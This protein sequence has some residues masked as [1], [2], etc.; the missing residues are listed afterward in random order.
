[1]KSRRLQS[2]PA[3][4]VLFSL[5]P[6]VATYA[7]ITGVTAGTDL[8]GGGTSG[9]VTLNVNT[10]ALNSAYAQLTAANTFTGNQTVNGN[11]SATGVV[12]GGSY[13]I[14]SNLFAF[15][16]Y[17]NANAFL[18]FA[19]NTT[20]TGYYNTAVG[21]QAL[22]S[23]ITGNSNTAVGLEALYSNTQGSGNIASGGYALTSNTSGGPNGAFG[24][25]A[26]AANTTGGENDA[27][28]YRGLYSNST[29]DGN[30]AFGY[31]ALYYNTGGYNTASGVWA[32]YNNTTGSY[33]TASGNQALYLNATG[34]ENTAIGTMSGSTASFS[35]VT[36]SYNTFLG[37][38]AYMSSGS[39]SNATAIGAC[40]EVSATNSIVLGGV[41]C[42]TGSHIAVG[43]DVSA[44]TNILSVLKGGGPAIADGWSTYSSRR[45]KTNIRT[46]HNALAKVEQLRGVSYD[47]KDSGKHEVGVIAEEVG[48]VVPEVVSYE[49]NGKDATGVDYSRLTAL[50]I[51]AV[52]QQQKQIALQQSQIRKQLHLMTA[53]QREIAGLSRKVGV[54]ESSLR[55]SHAETASVLV[56]QSAVLPDGST[57]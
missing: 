18:G 27:F 32:L 25:E 9:N 56:S 30:D 5:F 21:Q 51:E 8:T 23:N 22:F 31:E 45:W 24:F 1:M 15:G 42:G 11:L 55:S 46:L 19:G 49:K 7:Q 57:K 6:W 54:L 2:L 47:L 16:S 12:T 53:Q 4:A 14:G 38:G 39:L 48:Q 41:G 10:S 17:S 44:P 26:L 28:G 43:I 13:Q 35:S 50:L 29:G 36:G 3:L 34:S 37:Y 52:K 40:A 33:N 20:T